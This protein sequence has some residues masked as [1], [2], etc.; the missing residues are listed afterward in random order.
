M[1]V[2]NNYK[3]TIFAC[4]GGYITQAVVNNLA[5]LLFLIF[6]ESYNIPLT[7]ITLLVTVNFVTQL[8]VDLVAANIADKIGYRPMIVAAH[9]FAA[10]GLAGMGLLPNIIPPF[11]GLMISVV[12]YAIGG[13]I[14]EVL[15]SPITEACPTDNKESVMSLLH[16]FYCWGVVAVVALSTLFLYFFGKESWQWLTL[17][18]ALFPLAN[19][20]Y[21][22]FVPICHLTKAGEGM[23]IK[24]LLCSGSFW[25][26]ALMMVTAGGS[27]LAMSQW[28]S[29][30]AES[31]LGVP[32][33]VGDLAGPC[34]FAMLM[35]LA[36]VINAKISGKTDILNLIIGSCILCIGCYLLAVI[37]PIPALGLVGCA[38]CGFSVGILWP[39]TFSLAAKHCPNGGTAMFGLFALAGD[40]GCS[41][42]PTLVGFV[43]DFFDGNLAYGLLSA[44][45]FPILLIIGALLC[46]KFIVNK[47]K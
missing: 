27:E 45:A 46:K 21:F 4:Y 13:G 43:S 37:A 3:H 28:S 12:L 33:A 25:I 31:G 41:G 5:P 14:I 1:S 16:S 42:G 11:T 7:Q 23:T 18:W 30:F 10:A 44:I 17:L 19:S 6:N 36:R 40:M 9:L 2:K 29:A 22:C 47:T 34:L 20:M 8:T 26:F 38:L 15:I 39:S 24:Q 35:G 32:K